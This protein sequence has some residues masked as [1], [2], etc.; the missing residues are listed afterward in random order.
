MH[1][2]IILCRG[3]GD[4]VDDT[5]PQSTASSGCPSGKDSCSGGGLDAINNYMDFTNNVCMTQFTAG[6]S[7]YLNLSFGH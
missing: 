5:P 7:L 4:F 1:A 2:M 6:V 3:P